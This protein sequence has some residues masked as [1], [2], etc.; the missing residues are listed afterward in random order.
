ML[1]NV[2]QIEEIIQ[3]SFKLNINIG[4][5]QDDVCEVYKCNDKCWFIAGRLVDKHI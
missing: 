5:V 3:L 1:S 2:F 4:I